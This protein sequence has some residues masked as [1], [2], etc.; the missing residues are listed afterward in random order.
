M[1]PKDFYD[2]VVKM[3]KAQRD[4]LQSNRRNRTA[5]SDSR[6]YEKIIDTEIK[7]VELLTHEQRYPR[8]KL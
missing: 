8:L 6:H 4:Y 2:N 3:R 5:L 1:T 7:R